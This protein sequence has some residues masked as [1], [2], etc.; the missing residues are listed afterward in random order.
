MPGTITPIGMKFEENYCH[1]STAVLLL[2]NAI[3]ALLH[4]AT[5]RALIPTFPASFSQIDGEPRRS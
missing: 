2:F 4:S 3:T 5:N 1:L